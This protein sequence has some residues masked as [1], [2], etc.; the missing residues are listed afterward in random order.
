MS[1]SPSQFEDLNEIESALR[2]LTPK[3]S[4][5]DRE[6]LLF[7]AGQAS[8]ASADKAPVRRLGRWRWATFASAAVAVAVCVAHFGRPAPEPQV[9]ERVVYVEVPAK[10]P[11]RPEPHGEMVRREPRPPAAEA[12]PELWRGAEFVSSR[13]LRL[14]HPAM[15]FDVDQLPESRFASADDGNTEPPQT[16][17]SM[18]SSML[19]RQRRQDNPGS[20][21]DMNRFGLQRFPF[22][23]PWG[24]GDEL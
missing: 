15:A 14:R 10:T 6:R 1:E 13:M 9:V 11:P 19:D 5:I 17:N 2:S 8:A 20:G 18:R 16:L 23:L 3:K 24:G 7:L 4:T 22:Q 21:P 12:E